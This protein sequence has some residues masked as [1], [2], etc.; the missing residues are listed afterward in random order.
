M[1]IPI[2]ISQWM[3]TLLL[4]FSNPEKWY[5]VIYRRLCKHMI[6]IIL[7][8]YLV[9]GMLVHMI[10]IKLTFKVAPSKEF[11]VVPLNQRKE[12]RG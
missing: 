6:R 2:L 5:V 4:R 3:F 11:G 8:I 10:A 7:A 1:D 12:E 9:A